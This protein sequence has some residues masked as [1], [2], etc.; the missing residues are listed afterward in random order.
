MADANDDRIPIMRYASSRHALAASMSR[1]AVGQRSCV[2]DCAP[3]QPHR[4]SLSGPPRAHHRKMSGGR[5]FL[6]N[7]TVCTL[8]G[9]AGDVD[10][11]MS[12]AC[13]ARFSADPFYL[14]VL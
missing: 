9:I 4:A 11:P 3:L 6:G 2:I 12:F 14:R 1:A 10:A 13:R 7:E 5:T 8:D